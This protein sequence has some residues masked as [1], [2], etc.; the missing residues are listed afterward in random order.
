MN[1]L[2]KVS[3][4]IS[5]LAVSASLLTMTGCGEEKKDENSSG[6]VV[7]YT[8]AVI[9]GENDKKETVS[10]TAVPEPDEIVSGFIGDTLESGGISVTLEK[11]MI[12]AEETSDGTKLL[13]AVFNIKN[14]TAEDLEVNSLTH[15][16]VSVDGKLAGMESVSSAAAM[17]MA[18][19]KVTDAE[20]FY[21]TIA[22]GNSQ[23]GYMTFEIPKASEEIIVSYCPYNYTDENKLGFSY[24][25]T[26]SEIPVI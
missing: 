20:K 17:S 11:V 15:F 21:T 6:D 26:V 19:K 8:T 5:V 4:L 13:C 1:Y 14:T 23:R 24:K 9:D 22:S 25:A 16:T 2:K 7:Y 10:E 3:A 12:T 18:K